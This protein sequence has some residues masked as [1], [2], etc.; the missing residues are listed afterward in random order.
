[1]GGSLATLRNRRRIFFDGNGIALPCVLSLR[2][3]AMIGR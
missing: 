1:M 2:F 3:A